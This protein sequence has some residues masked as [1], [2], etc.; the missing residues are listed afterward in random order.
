M[1]VKDLKRILDEFD[2]EDEVFILESLA[3]DQDEVP[4][5]EDHIQ[6]DNADGVLFNGVR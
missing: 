6:H 4:L 2:D 5:T 3:D 1:K